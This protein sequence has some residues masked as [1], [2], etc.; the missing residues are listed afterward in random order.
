MK[1]TFF[2]S[3]LL[4]VTIRVAGQIQNIDSLVNVLHTKNLSAGEQFKLYK[5]ILEGTGNSQTIADCINTG[6]PLAKK[7][8]NKMMESVFNEY[9]GRMYVEKAMYD[10][11]LFYFDKALEL[12][13]ESKDNKQESSVYTSYA[14]SYGFQGKYKELLEYQLKALKILEETNNKQGIQSALSNIGNAYAALN[15]NEHALEYQ[16]KALALAEELNLTYATSTA[17][18]AIASTYFNMKNFEEAENHMLKALELIKLLGNKVMESYILIALQE[19]YSAGTV[20]LEKAEKFGK[21][22]MEIAEQLN[23]PELLANAYK[24]MSSIYRIQERYKDCDM[25]AT[26]AWDLDSINMDLGIVI[27]ANLAYANIQL[28]NKQKAL[29]F[30]NKYDSIA[31]KYNEKSL[32]ESLTSQEIKYETQKK[33]I[34]IASLEEERRMY[35]WLG[36]AGGLLAI[37]LGI[38]LWLTMRN[39][40]KEK[41][42]IA[43][44]AVQDGEMGER[45]RIAEDLHDRLGGSLSAV[46][47]ELNNAENLQNVSIKLDECIKEI[48]EI[49]HNL[50]PRSLRLF[51]MKGALEDFSAQFPNVHFHFFGK[52]KRIR[53]RLEFIIYCCANELVTNSIRYSGAKDIN[54]QLI[55]SENHV[56][57]TVQDDGCGFDEKTVTGGIGLKNIR[58]RVASCNGKVDIISSPGKGTETLIELRIEN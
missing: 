45:A 2:I 57:L 24:G 31:K 44:K 42:L 26:K 53:E 32:H 30:F 48:R 52:E 4:L 49:T 51:G 21:E 43:S 39:Q 7:E 19:I 20:N 23:N 16:K 9:T 33:E 8:K 46:K 11:A 25:I 6:L 15:D 50:M 14:V 34:R 38:V 47:I 3:L 22:G 36:I 10:S 55:Q 5:T 27:T 18:Y 28:N 41:Q 17:H 40:R 54:V 56:S 35:V 1:Q 58:D 12:A 37:S 13:V 29:M